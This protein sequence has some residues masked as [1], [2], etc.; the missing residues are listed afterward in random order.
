MMIRTLIGIMMTVA[1]VITIAGCG[2]IQTI[3][4]AG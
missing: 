3:G 2:S 1:L 4:G